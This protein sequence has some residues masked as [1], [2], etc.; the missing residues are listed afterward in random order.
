MNVLRSEHPNPQSH[1][2]STFHPAHTQIRKEAVPSAPAP[3]LWRHEEIA[4]CVPGTQL[5]LMTKYFLLLPSQK[6]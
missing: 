2:V 3:W 6:H 1:S 4:V 5:S